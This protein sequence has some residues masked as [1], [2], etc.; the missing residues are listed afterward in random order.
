MLF[1]LCF[2]ASWDQFVCCVSFL[3]DFGFFFSAGLMMTD[4]Y[5]SFSVVSFQIVYNIYTVFSC[6]ALE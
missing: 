6:L 5:K 4:C 1:R 3:V 2:W